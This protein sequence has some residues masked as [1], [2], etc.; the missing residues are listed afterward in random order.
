MVGIDDCREPCLACYFVEKV[1]LFEA[2]EK[3]KSNFYKKSPEEAE[4]AEFADSLESLEH[5]VSG[6]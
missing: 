4:A 6:L 1:L 5:Q 2:W 3:L